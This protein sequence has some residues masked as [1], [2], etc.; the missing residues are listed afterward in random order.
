MEFGLSVKPP[1]LGTMNARRDVWNVFHTLRYPLMGLYACIVSVGWLANW[2]APRSAGAWWRGAVSGGLIVGFT[3]HLV[4]YV[5]TV[6]RSSLR[7]MGGDAE[8]EVARHL[9]TLR[10]KGWTSTH[11]LRFAGQTRDVDH[12]LVGRAGVIVLETK[13]LGFADTD[14]SYE[15]GVIDQAVRQLGE[16]T[17]VVRLR[18]MASLRR[19]VRLGIPFRVGVRFVRTDEEELHA[20]SPYASFWSENGVAATDCWCDWDG[21]HWQCRSC[22]QAVLQSSLRLASDC[23]V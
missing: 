20:D 18:L 15:R 16:Q 12:V 14:S 10:A 2:A 13:W 5:A 6:T 3:V 7:W 19:K 4:W 11:H 8:R 23:C 22:G 17:K 9:D 1:R 21:N